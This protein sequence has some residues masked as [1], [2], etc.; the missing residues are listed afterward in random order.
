MS[1]STVS[2]GIHIGNSIN[3]NNL[4]RTIQFH[5]SIMGVHLNNTLVG[6]H[7]GLQGIPAEHQN[8]KIGLPGK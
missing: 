1:A 8:P 4:Q 2:A 7:H 3:Q 6:T 5:P